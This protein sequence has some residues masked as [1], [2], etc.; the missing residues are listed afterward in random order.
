MSSGISGIGD[1][2]SNDL[3]K[4]T[5]EIIFTRKT[6]TGAGN[7]FLTI[8]SGLNVKI[9]VT[10]DLS[11]GKSSFKLIVYN[12]DESKFEKI[13]QF[14]K[15]GDIMVEIKV[16]YTFLAG[17]EFEGY[18]NVNRNRRNVE[19]VMIGIIT[20]ITEGKSA[21]TL[22]DVNYIISGVDIAEWELRKY[23]RG[24]NRNFKNVAGGLMDISNVVLD[25]VN[26]IPEIQIGLLDLIGHDVPGYTSKKGQNGHDIIASIA[27]AYNI[28]F[29]CRLGKVWFVNDLTTLN[30]L[31]RI[32]DI[33]YD[34][35][36]IMLDKVDKSEPINIFRSQII[37][38]GNEKQ[39][40][41]ETGEKTITYYM[42]T[43]LGIPGV[44]VGTSIDFRKKEDINKDSKLKQFVQNL[45]PDMRKN[46]DP[47]RL[48][49]YDLTLHYE[50]R[51]NGY[52]MS[53]TAIIEN[54]NMNEPKIVNLSTG[55]A[56]I[57]KGV[58]NIAKN[59][60]EESKGE[61]AE[62]DTEGIVPGEAHVKSGVTEFGAQEEPGT[63][64][65]A[66]LQTHYNVPFTL[67]YAGPGAGIISPLVPGTR[68]LRM[69]YRG[70]QN[71]SCMIGQFW[72]QGWPRPAPYNTELARNTSI[73]LQN[74]K[75]EKVGEKVVTSKHNRIEMDN[76]G[77]IGMRCNG[78]KIIIDPTLQNATIDFTG[79]G[80]KFEIEI[81]G[82][83]GLEFDPTTQKWKLDTGHPGILED[84]CPL[85]HTHN[86]VAFGVSSPPDRTPPTN[87]PLIPI[88]SS[89]I[90]GKGFP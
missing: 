32:P 63:I 44:T 7:I 88:T 28:Y 61:I 39:Q 47:I 69:P 64:P 60:A 19:T 18:G 23:T 9:D 2:N 55:K 42:F 10:Y 30:N 17:S 31:Q 67:P 1:L 14:R 50:N 5:H 56:G 51:V 29:I 89:N 77:K 21:E 65:I 24:Y 6:G 71:P 40:I 48:V 80:G 66:D 76:D 87:P 75:S 57:A 58:A 52:K 72:R 68:V 8:T 38:E 90:K 12:L 73:I 54:P 78:M 84:M 43:M 34:N 86:V 37:E 20:N 85:N 3:Y 70:N 74:A 16:G 27:K 15:S 36:L 79:A 33:N 25:I 35:A 81:T 11:T 53:G 4:L 46:T 62:I 22:G 13:R 45:G 26:S 59:V 41:I 82:F 49:V 83:G